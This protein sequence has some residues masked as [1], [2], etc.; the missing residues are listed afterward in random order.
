[1]H[2]FFGVLSGTIVQGNIIDKY[3]INGITVSNSDLKVGEFVAAREDNHCEK[4]TIS[5][6]EIEGRVGEYYALID[7]TKY[8]V[9]LRCSKDNPCYWSI[10][11]CEEPPKRYL[12][13]G[14]WEYTYPATYHRYQYAIVYKSVKFLFNIN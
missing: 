11:D 12:K 8:K 5:V 14:F 6:Y 4:M 9:L 1:M 10:I 7:G 13:D 3:E 2:G